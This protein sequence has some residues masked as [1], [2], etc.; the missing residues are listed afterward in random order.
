MRKVPCS[1][2]LFGKLDETFARQFHSGNVLV[3]LTTEI[4]M[5]TFSVI[6]ALFNGANPILGT[7]TGTGK[8]NNTYTE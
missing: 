3:V 4:A 6:L 1:N 5:E 2:F 7:L 8:Q